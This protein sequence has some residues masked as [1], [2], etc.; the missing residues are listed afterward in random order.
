MGEEGEYDKDWGINNGL[1]SGRPKYPPINI[2]DYCPHTDSLYVEDK[3]YKEG[4]NWMFKKLL[5]F[6]STN[7]E[8]VKILRD[9]WDNEVRITCDKRQILV[10]NNSNM[11]DYINHIKDRSYI[12]NKGKQIPDKARR[13]YNVDIKKNNASSEDWD[14]LNDLKKHI[15]QKPRCFTDIK[16]LKSRYYNEKKW[17]K[18]NKCYTETGRYFLN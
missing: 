2:I 7:M 3:I 1:S 6:S 13:Y 10:I 11:W 5:K 12:D 15:I 14:Y 4:D 17:E 18:I 8:I 16:E 9:C